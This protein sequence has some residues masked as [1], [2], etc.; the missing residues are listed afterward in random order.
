[1]K[2]R[3]LFQMTKPQPQI[4]YE[5]I[6]VIIVFYAIIL[7]LQEQIYHYHKLR[8]CQRGRQTLSENSL[9]WLSKVDVF[10]ISFQKQFQFVFYFIHSSLRVI[11]RKP[12]NQC[13]KQYSFRIGVLVLTEFGNQSRNNST[14]FDEADSLYDYCKTILYC[15]RTCCFMLC[16]T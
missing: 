1:M 6:N 7:A 13:M 15:C 10:P 9:M 11:F 2:L 14:R 3:F 16:L 8:K 5:S 4:C 12:L